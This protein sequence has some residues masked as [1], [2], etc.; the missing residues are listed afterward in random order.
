MIITDRGSGYG[1]QS[2]KTLFSMK[3]SNNSAE[4]DP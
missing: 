2:A 4:N 1:L 3:S